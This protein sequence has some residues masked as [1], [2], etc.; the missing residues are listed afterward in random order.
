MAHY[1]LARCRFLTRETAE[2]ERALNACLALDEQCTLALDLLAKVFSAVLRLFS[3]PLWLTL[4]TDKSY[5]CSTSIGETTR[6]GRIRFVGRMRLFVIDN[7][8]RRTESERMNAYS[9]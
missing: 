9:Y 3:F 5:L 1:Y 4:V 8:R 6:V 7:V 2:C